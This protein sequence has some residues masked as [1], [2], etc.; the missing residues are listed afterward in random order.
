[1]RTGIVEVT[2]PSTI[3]A[4]IGFITSEPTPALYMIG[5]NPAM[6]TL[7]VIVCRLRSARPL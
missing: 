7:T 4:A 1:M 5:I 2:M 3:G 6:T